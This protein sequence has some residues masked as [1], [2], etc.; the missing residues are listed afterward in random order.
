MNQLSS[1]LCLSDLLN[2]LPLDVVASNVWDELADSGNRGFFRGLSRDCCKLS[3]LLTA[4]VRIPCDFG[5]AVDY[6]DPS[7]SEN[8]EELRLAGGPF[9]DEAN[10]QS[11]H[12]AAAQR[13]TYLAKLPRLSRLTLSSWP[14]KAALVSLLGLCG[15][16]TQ[17]RVTALGLEGT[18]R[19][20][21]QPADL[22]LG[23]A[24]H[25]AFPS[26]SSLTLDL[27]IADEDCQS[28]PDF[29]LPLKDCPLTSV[30]M[31]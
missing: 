13:Y 17:G 16:A 14:N 21:G 11:W 9:V 30:R 19:E 12:K 5:I 1:E 10:A 4:Q 23:A 22:P 31:F 25:A 26:L 3:D 2:A 6:A 24:I 29:M 7:D 27:R 20:F 15:S 18:C 28:E 8:P